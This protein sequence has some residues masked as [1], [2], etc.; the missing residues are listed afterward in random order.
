MSIVKFEEYDGEAELKN[1]TAEGEASPLGG[2]R[3]GETG[4]RRDLTNDTPYPALRTLSTG[5]EAT[6]R[7]VRG[8]S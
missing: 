8:S 2:R 6:P 7:R 4:R 1:T 5:V 3:S